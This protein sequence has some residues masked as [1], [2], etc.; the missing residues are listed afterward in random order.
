MQ[1]LT[2]NSNGSAL[3]ARLHLEGGTSAKA[4]RP[5]IIVIGSWLTVKEQMPANYAP[6][7]AEAG[8][9]A[10]TFDFRGFG[11]SQG[12]PREVESARSKSEDI[13]N[14]AAFL[15]TRPEVD[16]ERIGV[17][18]ICASASYTAL[19]LQGASRETSDIKSVAM[20]AP[21]IHD[22]ELAAQL[23]GGE[24]GIAQRLGAARAARERYAATGEVEYVA[25][26]SNRDPSAAMY[27]E[28]DA[29]DYY[30]NPRRGAVPAWGARFAPMAWSE[31]LESDFVSLA[32]RFSI[33]LGI[34]TGESTATP[35]GV[36]KF[37]ADLPRRP[38]SIWAEGSQF[39]FYDKPENVTLATERA[40]AH[41]R[42]TLP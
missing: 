24:A 12:D 13:L 34:V 2:F 18:A 28:G 11:E 37:I 35:A 42:N 7:I 15:R 40:L 22:P 25:A 20:V 41:F 27:A 8:L 10:L 4:R 33:P 39:D 29:L 23:Y 9:A 32:P 38:D 1:T 26:A 21:W 36:K 3:S 6:L 16:P 31:W 17:L 30:L 19:A 14:A 5:G